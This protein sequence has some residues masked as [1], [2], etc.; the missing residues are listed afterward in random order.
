M[1]IVFIT[2]FVL[3]VIAIMAYL[4][5]PS[6]TVF[7]IT[8]NHLTVNT[9]KGNP[10]ARFVAECKEIAE[11]RKT[12]KGKIFGIRESGGIKLNFS[13]SITDSE[14]QIFRN[15]WPNDYPGS[16]PPPSSGPRKKANII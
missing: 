7:V 14:R 3:Y 16:N 15:V 9:I 1:E 12:I 8:I 13:R 11:I 2:V 6:K 10:P 4:V 5:K